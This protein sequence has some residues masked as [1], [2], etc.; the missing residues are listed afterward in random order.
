M[1]VDLELLLFIMVLIY[2]IVYLEFDEDEF[3]IEVCLDRFFF[4]LF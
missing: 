1:K 4:M 2:G 3:V